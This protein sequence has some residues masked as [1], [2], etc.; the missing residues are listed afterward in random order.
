MRVIECD[1]GATL[2]AADD[3]E[4]LDA[5]RR[6]VDEAHPRENTSD[7]DLRRK[8]QAQAYDATDS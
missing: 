1:C 5:M 3:S 7:E 2:T 6:H 4:L 8:I